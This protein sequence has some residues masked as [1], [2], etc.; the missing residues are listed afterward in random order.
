M[1]KGGVAPASSATSIVS[2]TSSLNRVLKA[3]SELNDAHGDLDKAEKE[4]AGI[5][6]EEKMT[7][8]MT[9]EEIEVEIEKSQD[10]LHNLREQEGV[11]DRSLTEKVIKRDQALLALKLQND[12]FAKK[13]TESDGVAKA[14]KRGET[15]LADKERE[16]RSKM[17]K[18]MKIDEKFARCNGMQ[19]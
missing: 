12:E 5:Q 9:P 1:K 11:V 2:H 14:S 3:M 6:A 10:I 19:C 15:E 17:L 18:M 7:G 13:M 8:M 4:E 16:F